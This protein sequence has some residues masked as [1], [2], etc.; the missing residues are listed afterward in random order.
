[1]KKTRGLRNNNP[2]N[3]RISTAKWKGLREKQTDSEFCQ[4]DSIVYGYRAAIKILRTYKLKYNLN[5][6]EK[7]LARFAPS[8]ENDTEAYIQIVSRKAKILRNVDLDLYDKNLVVRLVEA[9]SYVENGESATISD[10]K[11]GYDLI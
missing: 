11:K 7:M 4:F 5:T 2:L 9:M 10:I 3:V 8:S 6:L 1:M